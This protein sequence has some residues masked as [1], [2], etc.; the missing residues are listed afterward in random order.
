MEGFWQEFLKA[1]MLLFA[2]M[3]PLATVPVLILLTKDMPILE[4]R[5]NIN[6]AVLVA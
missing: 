6:R 5:R 2:I 4:Q 3:D 1:F